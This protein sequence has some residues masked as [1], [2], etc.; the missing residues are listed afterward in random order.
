VLGHVHRESLVLQDAAA[1]YPVNRS[2]TPGSAVATVSPTAAMSGT[3]AVGD[4]DDAA[5]A[6]ST[7]YVGNLA[8]VL[9][10]AN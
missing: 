1:V 9:F 3:G 4:D 2:R 10:H 6:A 7:N 5:F 8:E